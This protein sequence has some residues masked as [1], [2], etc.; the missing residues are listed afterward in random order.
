MPLMGAQILVDQN[1]W[2]RAVWR[3]GDRCD[4]ANPQSLAAMIRDIIAHPIGPDTIGGH[5]HRR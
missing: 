4:Q 3:D 1:A 5:M 2:F